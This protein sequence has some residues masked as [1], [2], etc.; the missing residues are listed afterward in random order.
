MKQVF[1][2]SAFLII[3][4]AVIISLNNY[5]LS[6]LSNLFS[7][8][9]CDKAIHYRVDIVDPKFNLSRENFLSDINQAAQIWNN[10]R[11]KSLFSYD[12][13]GNLSINLIY[14]E[15]QSLTT[16]INQLE[17]TVKSDQQSLNPKVNEYQKLASEF[18]QKLE[19][20]N[21]EIEYWN[22][23]G[24]AP[25][26]EYNKIIQKQHDLQAEADRLNAMAQN[27][28]VSTSA[29]NSEISKLNQTI[30]VFNN[31]LEQ[32]P[33]EGIYKGPE[34]RIEIYFNISK[35]ELVH[36]LAHELGHALGL[37]HSSNQKAIMYL[38]TNQSVAPSKD[39]IQA[40]ENVCKKH[41][42]FEIIQNYLTQTKKLWN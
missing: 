42:L 1:I 14:D 10:L 38:R 36:T 27:L 9:V 6:S 35:T 16:Q 39:D 25:T 41:T 22:S 31:A 11:D 29:Y 5:N 13:K 7:Y 20:L 17:N 30:S 4:V 15:R 12:P 23:K 8:S 40:L 37:T 26:D 2:F 18:R 21:K 19:N 28:N 34:D 24:G 3:L 32:R 33:E